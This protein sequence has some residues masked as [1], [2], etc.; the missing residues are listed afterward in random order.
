MI[1][2]I[3][4]R[5]LAPITQSLNPTPTPPTIVLLLSAPQA[6]GIPVE[7]PYRLFV[8]FL[9]KCCSDT[10][11][12]VGQ[13]FPGRTV[14]SLRKHA[15][16]NTVKPV[17]SSHP[18]EAKNVAAEGRWLLNTV[19]ICKSTNFG[20]AFLWLLNTGWLLNRGDH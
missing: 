18:W 17:L 19:Q 16:S 4:G 7:I 14:F 8:Q 1:F 3:Q 11:L 5:G 20:A 12:R 2:V 9:T 10:S 6:C 13:P 15:Y